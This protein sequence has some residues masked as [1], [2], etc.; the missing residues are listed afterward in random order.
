VKIIVTFFRF[1]ALGSDILEV[2]GKEFKSYFLFMILPVI[3]GI[4]DGFGRL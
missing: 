4:V 3:H 1:L 2:H